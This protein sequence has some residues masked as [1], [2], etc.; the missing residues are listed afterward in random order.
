MVHAWIRAQ[1]CLC[2]HGS[3]HDSNNIADDVQIQLQAF[4]VIH[5]VDK[6]GNAATTARK[7]ERGRGFKIEISGPEVD[8][9]ISGMA[10]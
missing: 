1:T 8:P 9:L 4:V 5:G 10:S 3:K 2:D 7:T 6:F